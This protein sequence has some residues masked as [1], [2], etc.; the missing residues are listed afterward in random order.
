MHFN[1]YS[2]TKYPRS[3][4]QM[5][6]FQRKIANDIFSKIKR[7]IPFYVYIQTGHGRTIIWNRVVELIKANTIIK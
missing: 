2:K 1:P 3:K 6:K 5:Y 7:G 4:L